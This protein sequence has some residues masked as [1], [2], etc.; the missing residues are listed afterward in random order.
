MTASRIG[1][2]ATVI[3]PGRKGLGFF[4]ERLIRSMDPK[5]FQ[6]PPVVYI[7]KCFAKEARER[8]PSLNLRSVSCRPSSLWEI[9]GLPWHI[10]KE[11]VRI[12]F[13]GRD[14][15]VL[16]PLCRTV[17]YLFEVP[18][19]RQQALMSSGATW[20]DRLA[21]RI[22]R[23]RFT[24]VVR[25]ATKFI[26]SSTFT[27]REL[28]S[29]YG[30]MPDRITVVYPGVDPLFCPAPDEETRLAARDKFTCGR[31]YALHFATGDIR[32]N[33]DVALRIFK[34]S[35]DSMG[36]DLHLLIAG[37]PQ[38]ERHRWSRVID[39]NRL[40]DRVSVAGYLANDDLLSVY[41]G[42]DAYLDPTRYEGFGFQ[43]LEAMACGVP[44]LSSSAASVPEV[45]GEAGLL[46]QPDDIQGFSQGLQRVFCDRDFAATLKKKGLEQAK[47]F[48]L[49]RSVREIQLVLKNLDEG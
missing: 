49:E 43:N 40:T 1:I 35:L 2:D 28:G 3:L 25:H 38:P 7:D 23:E 15:T 26:V 20:Y 31:R 17:V 33:T 16:E 8:W 11:G 5:L 42:A 47:R 14:R 12:L 6:A 21:M 24:Q 37:V 45:V 9:Y 29:R 34:H 22:S 48:G 27:C 44:V 39:Q 4:L 32:D 46:Y 30:V 18:Y 36:G 41:Q 19:F 13:T 10:K